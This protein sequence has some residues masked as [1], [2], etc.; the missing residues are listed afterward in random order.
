MGFVST[1]KDD[2][3]V[4]VHENIN[5]QISFH[6]AVGVGGLRWGLELGGN[7]RGLGPRRGLE[8]AV[9]GLLLVF[10]GLLSRLSA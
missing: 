2:F 6:V 7:V 9:G 8:G 3:M 1:G 4:L 10:L 5:R